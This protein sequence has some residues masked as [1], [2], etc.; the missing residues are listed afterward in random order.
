MYFLRR[1]R[2][3]ENVFLSTKEVQLPIV[4]EVENDDYI[5]RA[6]TTNFVYDEKELFL[7]E[8]KTLTEWNIVLFFEDSIQIG[9]FSYNRGQFKNYKID[10]F[11]SKI[12]IKVQFCPDFSPW[13]NGINEQ[14]HYSADV[15]EEDI[16]RR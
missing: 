10:K 4:I 12:G 9:L 3:G 15:T 13:S 1:F 6:V 7:C 2:F 8:Q 16:R 11:A 14:N 5:K